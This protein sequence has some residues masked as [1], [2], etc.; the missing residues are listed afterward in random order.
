MGVEVAEEETFK[1]LGGEL[2]PFEGGWRS[3]LLTGWRWN[4]FKVGLIHWER[5]G[6]RIG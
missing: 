3:F 6:N 5:I 1:G 4:H 2:V